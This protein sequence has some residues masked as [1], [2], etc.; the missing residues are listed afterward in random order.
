MG[1]SLGLVFA[2]V[3]VLLFVSPA[4]SLVWPTHTDPVQTVTYDA[5]VRGAARLAGHPVP[6]PAGLPPQWRATSARVDGGGGVP[7]TL[8]VGFVTPSE[9]YA[10]VEVTDGGSY[11][12]LRKLLGK[13]GARTV[14]GST[15]VAGVTWQLRH[16]GKEQLAFTRTDGD[17]TIVVTGSAPRSE[18]EALAA[19]LRPT[20][21]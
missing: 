10:G 1:R 4:R 18:L 5:Q 16:D 20:S 8:H 12:F 14:D 9:Q 11:E 19:A 15:E 3:A 6:G 2:F 17:L 21:A 13:R 7:M